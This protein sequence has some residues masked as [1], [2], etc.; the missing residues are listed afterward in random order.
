MNPRQARLSLVMGVFA[1]LGSAAILW[2]WW[3]STE[4]YLLWVGREWRI[5]ATESAIYIRLENSSKLT[6]YPYDPGFNRGEWDVHETEITDFF[7]GIDMSPGDVV[8]P[9]WFILCA[10]L[11]ALLLLWLFLM[12]R[13]ARPRITEG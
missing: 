8:L 2:V 4:N 11:S 7:P 10:Y 12:K 1:A 6:N 5:A 13:H 9:M 3:D